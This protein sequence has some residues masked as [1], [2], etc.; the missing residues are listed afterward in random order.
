VRAARHAPAVDDVRHERRESLRA[1]PGR[2]TCG[3][4]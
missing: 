4:S 3:N 2:F 1:I